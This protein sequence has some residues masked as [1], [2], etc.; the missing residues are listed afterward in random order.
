MNVGCSKSGIS[1]M[2]YAIAAGSIVAMLGMAN[3][4]SAITIDFEGFGPFVNIENLNLGGVE[5]FIPGSAFVQTSF[6]VPGNPLTGSRG[7]EGPDVQDNPFVGQF[8]GALAGNVNFV[9]IAL[10][11]FD[12][13]GG[14]DDTLFLRAYN[15][16]NVLIGEDTASLP[17][18]QGPGGRTLSVSVVGIDRIEFGSTGVFPNSVLADNLTFEWGQLPNN[19]PIPEPTSMLLLGSGFAGILVWRRKKANG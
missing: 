9:S 13:P 4:A 17:G 18:G 1:R 5:I 6:S 10:G 8:L 16:L 14:D 3:T 19:N 7:I 2:K 11:D 15:S 12:G